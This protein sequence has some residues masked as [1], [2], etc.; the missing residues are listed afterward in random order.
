MDKVEQDWKSLT[1]EEK[2]T[3]IKESR[4]YYSPWFYN[5]LDDFSYSMKKYI[6]KFRGKHD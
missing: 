4:V 6:L 1:I 2:E 5:T 3:I